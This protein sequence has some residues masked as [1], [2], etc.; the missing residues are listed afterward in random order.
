MFR[1][2]TEYYVK[3]CLNELGYRSYK[4]GRLK[5]FVIRIKSKIIL[6][7][8]IEVNYL[9]LKTRNHSLKVAICNT[10]PTDTMSLV[11]DTF[12]FLGYFN[13]GPSAMGDADNSS[14]RN[15]A[16]SH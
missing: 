16:F 6:L 14:G 13:F 8:V 11:V 15:I 5:N 7:L 1:N 2:R 9:P 12:K 4:S 3:L 10:S